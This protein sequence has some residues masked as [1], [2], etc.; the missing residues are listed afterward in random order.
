M[1]IFGKMIS[2]LILPLIAVVIYDALMS[3]FFRAPPSWGF[4]TALFLYGCFFMLGA[5][6]CHSEKKHVAVDAL[7]HQV[8]PKAARAL[9]IFAELVVLAVVLVMLYV[10]IPIAH[11]AF[12]RLERSTH[13]TPFNPQVWWYRWVIP[14]TCALISWQ[15]FVNMLKLIIGREPAKDEGKGEGERNAA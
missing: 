1:K 14:I 12:L 4:E 5:A 15:A 9:S 6:Y 13:Q 2:L 8:G 3:Y 7:L 10:S 11:R